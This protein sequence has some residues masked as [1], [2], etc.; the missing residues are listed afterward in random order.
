MAAIL[1][2]GEPQRQA[3][4]TGRLQITLIVVETAQA[5]Q[6]INKAQIC[7]AR[8]EPNPTMAEGYYE[9]YDN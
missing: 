7:H 2:A 5:I 6:L 3:A 4:V 9:E 8:M 1:A